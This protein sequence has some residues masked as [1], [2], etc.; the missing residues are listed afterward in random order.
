MLVELGDRDAMIPGRSLSG[1]SQFELLARIS[2]SGN[3]IAESGD[4]F[5]A[6]IFRSGD[7]KAIDLVIDQQTP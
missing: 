4:W 7:D 3:P 2:A 1:F 5:G 6:L